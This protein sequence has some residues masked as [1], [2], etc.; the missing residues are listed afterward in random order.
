[1]GIT[2]NNDPANV[3]AVSGFYGPGAWGAYICSLI[4]AWY[5][6]LLRPDARGLSD[7]IVSL[8]YVN[9]AAIDLLIRITSQAPEISYAS[10]AAASA[11]TMWGLQQIVL[12]IAVCSHTTR[13]SSPAKHRLIF[14]ILGMLI[15]SIAAVWLTWDTIVAR[16][17][18]TL[19]P[20]LHGADLEP[21]YAD[22]D[23]SISV[24]FGF[25]YYGISTTLACASLWSVKPGARAF[26]T[27]WASCGLF[28]LTMYLAYQ[29]SPNFIRACA[30]Q[31]ITESDQAFALL[32]GLA[33]LV[34]QVAPDAWSRLTGRRI[35]N[36][37][38]YEL[39]RAEETDV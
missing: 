10:T 14:G 17:P 6:I 5:T 23:E 25:N 15:P 29:H 2:S 8:L 4:S 31:S 39:L 12:Q 13:R 20:H 37:H 9:W 1:M 18:R 3:A 22:Y 35:D 33:A 32:C 38:T 16:E 21:W 34:Y 11:V 30:P 24:I 27:T 36:E 7:L 19:P 26:F 28:V